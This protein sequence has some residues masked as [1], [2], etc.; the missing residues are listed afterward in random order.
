MWSER[1]WYSLQRGWHQQE[2]GG[3]REPH[4][5]QDRGKLLWLECGVREDIPHRVT[6]I[7]RGRSERALQ[8]KRR[9]SDFVLS[10]AGLR[11]P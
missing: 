7:T 1:G 6:E 5:I 4:A 11:T 8:P 10:A 9:S 2:V 3:G